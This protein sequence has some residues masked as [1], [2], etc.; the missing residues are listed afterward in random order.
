[1]KYML[2]T[3]VVSEMRKDTCNPNVK[4]FTTKTDPQE[5]F[6]SVLTLGEISCGVEI[7]PPSKKRHELFLWLYSLVPVWFKDRIIPLDEDS[8]L[9]WGKVCAGAGRTLQYKDSILAATA[10]RNR[11]VLVTRNAKDFE[12]IGGLTVLNPWE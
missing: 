5:C 3:N 2:D 4:N 1:M 9:E 11:C 8:M 12:G 10:I 7:L 6:I